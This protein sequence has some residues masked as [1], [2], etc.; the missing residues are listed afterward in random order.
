M[1]ELQAKHCAKGRMSIGAWAVR[2]SG[3]H[4]PLTQRLKIMIVYYLPRFL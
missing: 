4:R 2:C 3:T 1:S